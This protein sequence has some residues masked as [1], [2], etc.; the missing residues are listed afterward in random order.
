MCVDTVV[1]ALQA[2]TYQFESRLHI[3]EKN[4]LQ[5]GRVDEQFV[6]GAILAAR[7]HD[8]ERGVHHQRASVEVWIFKPEVDR[9]R[10]YI[11]FY[12]LEDVWFISIHPAE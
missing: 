7:G 1:R 4:Y 12:V 10:W 3:D 5:A 9:Q 6:I 2:G 8:A 11:K